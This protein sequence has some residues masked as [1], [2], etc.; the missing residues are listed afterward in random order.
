MILSRFNACSRGDGDVLALQGVAASTSQFAIA[1]LRKNAH[2]VGQVAPT[3]YLLKA[4][5]VEIKT[6]STGGK[7]ARC[8]FAYC[9]GI[10]DKGNVSVQLIEANSTRVVWAYS[11]NKQKGGSK[12]SQSMAEA[13]AKHLKEFVEHNPLASGT[14][15][16]QSELPPT[17][18]SHTER[19]VESAVPMQLASIMVKS[20]P[21]G[22]DINVD[23]KWMG[24]T[25]STIQLVPGEHQVSIEKDELR[26]WQRTMTVTV[27]GSST[28]DATLEKP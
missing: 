13:V 12:N 17:D 10:E 2:D 4:A 16:A 5:P 25:P 19:G 9:A 23:G 1:R 24:S 11:V 18:N 8:L 26:A 21:T 15:S 7:V 20:T 22:A 3:A 27:G 6:E 14:T 28:I